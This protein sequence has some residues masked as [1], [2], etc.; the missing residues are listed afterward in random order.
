VGLLFLRKLVYEGLHFFL[1]QQQ[2]SCRVA[3]V[4]DGA[5]VAGK[6]QTGSFILTPRPDGWARRN[7]L[8]PY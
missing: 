1:V 6:G 2:S 5:L 3:V 8:G 4:G 7:E